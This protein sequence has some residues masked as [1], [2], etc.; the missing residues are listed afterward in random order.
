MPRAQ[1][2]LE[3]LVILAVILTVSGI[4]IGYMTGIISGQRSSVTI[5][6]CKQVAV[7]CKASKLLSP[8]DPCTAC[9]TACKDS[10]GVELFDGAT[11]CCNRGQPDMVFATSPGCYACSDTNPCTGA[12]LH[13]IDH[14]CRVCTPATEGTYCSAG[15]HCIDNQCL[16]CTQATEGTYCS[17]P[18][19]YCLGNKCVACRGDNDCASGYICNSNNV[20]VAGC[21]DPSKCA[22]GQSCCSG[23]CKTPAC[24]VA[25]VNTACQS[26]GDAICL[27]SK[28]CANAADGCI[29]ACDVK[30]QPVG[31][32]TGCPPTTTV[33]SCRVA[34]GAQS[35]S[36]KTVTTY[37]CDDI[38]HVCAPTITVTETPCDC[39]ICTVS[40]STTYCATVTTCTPS[41]I[42]AFCGRDITNSRSCCCTVG[43]F[44]SVHCTSTGMC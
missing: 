29:A 30:Y 16:V 11:Y 14:D 15:T 17:A 10:S 40:G 38:N 28:T 26:T 24:T 12:G 2:S 3:Y 34:H 33:W 43:N 1:G 5:T 19:P 13:C 7:D 22:S 42:G 44:G 8:S 18:T 36:V 20:C 37:A 31:Y 25:N 21:R 4:V 41:S 39:S 9:D 32:S 27:L 23:Q 6:G 35:W